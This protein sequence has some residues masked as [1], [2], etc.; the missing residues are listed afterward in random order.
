M[1]EALDILRRLLADQ[2]L[3]VLGT[4]GAYTSLV[5]F[6][7]AEDGRDLLFATTRSTRKYANLAVD[8]R[9]CMLIDDRSNRP[10]D[11][12]NAAA[13]TARGH[14]EEVEEAGWAAFDDVFLGK[15]PY[16]RGFL[17]S[18]TCARLRLRVETYIL[19]TRFQDV[20]E[21]RAP[22]DPFSP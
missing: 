20:V 22:C 11:F 4:H 17:A 12:A 9:A 15:H 21:L 14:A 3:G 1:S 16:L 13:V 6:A 19:V 7:A 8:P 2:S 18:P 5:A 10:E